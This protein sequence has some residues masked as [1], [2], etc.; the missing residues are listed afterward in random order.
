MVR[1]LW[2]DGEDRQQSEM[3]EQSV[4]MAKVIHVAQ[5]QNFGCRHCIPH[6]GVF[7]RAGDNVKSSSSLWL[8]PR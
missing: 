4:V 8:W 6:C 1:A 7:V 5:S 3:E 2:C